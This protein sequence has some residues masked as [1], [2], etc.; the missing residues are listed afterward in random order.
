MKHTADVTIVIPTWQRASWLRRC[1]LAA[2]RQ[3][4]APR[5]VLVVGRHED[6]DAQTVTRDAAENARAPVRWLEVGRPGHVAPVREGLEASEGEI[7]AF[8]D[9]DAEAQQG[10]L[11]ACLEPFADPTVVCVGG[12]VV[13][14]GFR[15]K[16]RRDAGRIRW[17]GKHIGNLGAVEASD[18]LQVDG[19]MEGNW[20]WRRDIFLGL[21]FDPILDFDDAAMYGLDLCLQASSLGYKVLYQPSARVTH[22]VAPRDDSL[23]RGDRPR[24]TYVF[25]RNYTYIGLKH[26]RGIRRAAFIAWWWGVGPRGAYGLLT[27]A[28]DLAA[29]RN[30]VRQL[31]AAAF[32]GKQEGLRLWRAR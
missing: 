21:E 5:E 23:D 6:S 24:R 8:L 17:Y 12:R 28:W 29:R 10:W 26:F 13:S 20:A 18:P 32:A 27:S 14:R 1:L 4:P 9:D 3:E 30:G 7:V 25:A 11:A 15:G 31:T 19:V 16:V 2:L 22:H